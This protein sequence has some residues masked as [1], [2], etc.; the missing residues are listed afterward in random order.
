[1]LGLDNSGKTTALKSLAG[2]RRAGSSRPSARPE[3]D[4]RPSAGSQ[5]DVS[6]ITP[7]QGFNIKSV[8]QAGFKLNVWDIGGAPLRAACCLPDPSPLAKPDPRQATTAPGGPPCLQARS[9]SA[10]TGRTT[11][12]TP[13][14]LCAPA[15]HAHAPVQR[16][17]VARCDQPPHTQSPPAPR[18]TRCRLYVWRCVSALR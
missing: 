5:E 7:T 11:T 12:R 17:R 14:R 10:L 6:H 9:T 4:T 15:H 16:A 13:T 1:M 18:H 3:P 2:V 8:T